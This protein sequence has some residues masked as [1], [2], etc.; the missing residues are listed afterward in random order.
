MAYYVTSDGEVH[1]Y[2]TM[3]GA[4]LFNGKRVPHCEIN[5]MRLFA[6]REAAVA[7]THGKSWC[8]EHSTFDICKQAR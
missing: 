7:F 1:T 8:M 2:E 3:K 5:A 6:T 4:I